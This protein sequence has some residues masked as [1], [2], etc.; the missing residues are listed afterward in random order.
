[1][2]EEISDCLV[3]SDLN[4]CSECG[5]GVLPPADLVV[6]IAAEGAGRR[7]EISARSEAGLECKAQLATWAAAG[8]NYTKQ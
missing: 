8:R 1:M 3:L 2:N 7:L 6:T 4:L 5:E